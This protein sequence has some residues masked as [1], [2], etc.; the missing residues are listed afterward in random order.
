MAA[1]KNRIILGLMTMGPDPA[2]GARITSLDEFKKILDYFQQIGYDEVDTARLYCGGKQEEFTAAAGWKERGLKMATK[3]YPYFPGAFKAA[4]LREMMEKSLQELKTDSVDI[5]Y[6]HAAD[7]TV[8]VTETLEEMDA[9]HKEGKFSTFG[10]SNFSAYEIAE[11]WT[12]C[13]ERGWV[14]PTLYQ[15]LY[16]C[17]SRSLETEIVPCCRRYGIDIVIFNPL[18]GGLLSGRYKTADV[19][20]EGRYSKSQAG[21]MYR[22]RYFKDATFE[23]LHILEPVLAKHGLTMLEV[24]LRWCV[25]HS[26]LNMTKGG[27]DGVIIGVSSFAHLESNLSNLEKGP[28]PEDVVKVLD[29]AWLLVKPTTGNPWH[30]ELK[31]TYDAT[32]A[33]AK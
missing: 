6:L 20:A 15:G 2:H 32:T 13:N 29:E 16:N 26:V 30:G 9:L 19:P 22:A 1:T 31:Y 33:F 18:A 24:A 21:D 17:I 27:N 14:K 25:H 11:I 5:F 7:R 10:L 8:P 4:K 3:W 28:L 23:A 12:I